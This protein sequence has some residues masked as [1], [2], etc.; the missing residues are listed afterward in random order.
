MLPLAV[1]SLHAIGLHIYGK[2]QAMEEDMPS[3][4]VDILLVD[5]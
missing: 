3:D 4:P 2:L 1:P 5:P